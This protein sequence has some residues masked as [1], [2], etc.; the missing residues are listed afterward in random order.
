MPAQQHN[1]ASGRRLYAFVAS[2]E[3]PQAGGLSTCVARGLRDMQRADLFA[4][5]L[6][7]CLAAAAL[8]HH[9]CFA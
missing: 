5:P 9:Y 8:P 6:P 3:H 4:S 1:H 7:P 2:V